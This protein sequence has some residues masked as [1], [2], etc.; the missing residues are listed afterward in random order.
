VTFTGQLAPE[1][2]AERT[3]SARALVMPSRYPEPYGLVAV[4]AMWSGIPLVVAKSALLAAEIERRG[5][6]VVCNPLDER[7]F[8]EALSLLARDDAL[9]RR[10][11]DHAFADTRDLGLTPEA[12]AEEL[13]RAFDDVLAGSSH[14]ASTSRVAPQFGQRV[15]RPSGS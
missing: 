12:W 10:M 1:A 3:R 6:G 13:E 5:A 14:A 11:S 8:A 2:V 4:E 9:A 7:E 15:A